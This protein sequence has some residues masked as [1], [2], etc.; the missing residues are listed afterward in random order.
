[1]ASQRNDEMDA[2]LPG[3]VSFMNEIKHTL[4]RRYGQ[5]F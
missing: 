1:M 2:L 3:K 5:A 4:V